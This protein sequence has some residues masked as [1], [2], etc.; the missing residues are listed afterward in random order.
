MLDSAIY[1]AEKMK[2]D[3]A[4]KLVDEDKKAIDGAVE[5][6]KKVALMRMPIKRST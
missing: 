3:T 5:A 4:E 6:A 1:Q 2:S